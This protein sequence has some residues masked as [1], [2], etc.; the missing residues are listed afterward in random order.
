M[1]APFRKEHA[2]FAREH[3]GIIFDGAMEVRNPAIEQRWAARG[4]AMDAAPTYALQSQM[5]TTVNAGIPAYLTNYMDPELVRVLTTPLKAEEIFSSKKYGD[6]TTRTAQFPI[7]ESSGEVSTYGDY[8]NNG[9]T[10]A[11]VDFV[12]RQ[13]YGFQTFTQW[14]DQQLDTMGLAKIDYAAELNVASAKVLTTELNRGWFRGYTGIDAYGILNDPSLSAYLTP[15]TK[16]GGGTAWSGTSALGTELVADV[17][18]LFTA[19]VRQTGGNIEI[20]DELILVMPT[21]VAPY[22]LKPMTNVYGAQSV[23]A[24]L[25]EAF[26]KMRFVSTVEHATTAGNVIQLI[27]PSIQGQKT[28]WLGFTERMRAHDIVR[29]TSSTHQKKSAGTWGAI[30]KLPIGIAQGIGY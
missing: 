29:A 27:A 13:S 5:V 3:Y 19:L 1:N 10:N 25:L 16:T 4:F 15:S 2:Q 7:V 24:F 14:G 9:S 21:L 28:G 6:W 22:L 23:K 30:I 20:G 11:N 12:P 17:T 8:N 18:A 26:P